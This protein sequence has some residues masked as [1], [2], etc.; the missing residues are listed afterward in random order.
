MADMYDC[1]IE[2][3]AGLVVVHSPLLSYVHYLLHYHDDDY[4]KKFIISQFSKDSIVEAKQ[5]LCGF[6]SDHF[7]FQQRKDS[8]SRSAKEAHLADIIEALKYMDDNL[9]GK[10][11]LYINSAVLMQLAKPENLMEQRLN[12][13]EQK[14][15]SLISVIDMYVAENNSLNENIEKLSKKTYAEAVVGHSVEG[16]S[17]PS[18]QDSDAE[19]K[20]EA[21]R[22][23]IT[24]LNTIT[25]SQG[26]KS[27]NQDGKYDNV[28]SKESSTETLSV[29]D[30][31]QSEVVTPSYSFQKR[32]N[33]QK[34][35]IITGNSVTCKGVSGAPEPTRHLFIKRINEDTDNEA[36][37][38]MIQ[39]YGFCIK[40]FRCISH[41]EAR[42]KS[43][44]LSVPAS[45]FERLFDEKLW[46]EGVVV[47][48]FRTPKSG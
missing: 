1:E 25:L 37:Q 32:K 16:K 35:L 41:P 19:T 48:M 27:G 28:T 13:L 22:T 26:V 43:F 11:K 34:R 39:Q 36:V 42:F 38:N 24:S 29:P 47:R 9:E 17:A 23:P 8:A 31:R 4:V 21:P 44:K 7:I 18:A 46:P 40:D 14:V 15:S 2:E 30:V 33:R 12:L 3:N 6:Y 20:S 45:Q 10:F 5:S